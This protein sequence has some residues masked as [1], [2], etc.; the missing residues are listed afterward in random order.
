RMRRIGCPVWVACAAILF[1]GATAQPRDLTFEQRV[2]A[3]EAI[4]RLY[5]S[6]Q[7]GATRPFEEAVPRAVLEE[8]VRTYLTQSA[9]LDVFWKTP[10]TSEMLHR[11]LERMAAS[12]RM[13]ERLRQLEAVLG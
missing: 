12:T 1:Q 13:P 7:I 11:E 5:Y 2:R 3:Q 6:H 4:E 9:A 10:V 8:K